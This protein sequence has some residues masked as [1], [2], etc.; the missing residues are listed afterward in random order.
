MRS[1]GIAMGASRSGKAVDIGPRAL[2][3]E[4]KL[5]IAVI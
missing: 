2:M 3:D 5:V 1:E 4:E